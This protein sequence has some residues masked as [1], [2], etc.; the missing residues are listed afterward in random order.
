VWFLP[1]YRWVSIGCVIFLYLGAGCFLLAAVRLTKSSNRILTGLGA[2]GAN[3]YSSYL[4]HM[5]FTVWGHRL[6]YDV[7][8]TNSFWLYFCIY[9]FGSL[10]VGYGMNRLIERP[11]LSVR[12]R[13]FPGLNRR[14]ET[15]KG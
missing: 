11:A 14:P 3:S 10:V 5:P 15:K 13:L 1:D 4:W 7:W 9:V 2:I 12:D 8:K 6:V